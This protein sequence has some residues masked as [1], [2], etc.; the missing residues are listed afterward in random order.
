MKKLTTNSYEDRDIVKC[1]LA[2]KCPNPHFSELL[3]QF[4]QSVTPSSSPNT[5]VLSI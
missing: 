3:G 5:L 2:D 1:H 4:G